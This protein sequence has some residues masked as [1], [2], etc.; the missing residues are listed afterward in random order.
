MVEG[1]MTMS[2]MGIQAIE[3]GIFHTQNM[4]FN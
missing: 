2:A 4:H 1:Q 3:M